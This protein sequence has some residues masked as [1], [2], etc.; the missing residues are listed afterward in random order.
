[1]QIMRKQFYSPEASLVKVLEQTD[2]FTKVG[3]L[4]TPFGSPHKKDLHGHY[5]DSDTYFG[6]DIVSTKFGLYEH[7]MND[8]ANPAMAKMGKQQQI[9]GPAKHVKT[10]DAGR[11]FEIEV[12]RSLEY[13]DVLIDLIQ[14]GLMGASTQAFMNSVE[15]ANDGHILSWIE[16][17]V[18]LTPTPANKE[19]I[20]KVYEVVKSYKGLPAKFAVV[21]NNELVVLDDNSVVELVKEDENQPEVDFVEEIEQILE[22]A[23]DPD[24]QED[25]DDAIVLPDDLN[26]NEDMK[27]FIEAT[28]QSTVKAQVSVMMDIWGS[29]FEE[30]REML[31]GMMSK[32]VETQSPV[33]TELKTLNTNMEAVQ[34]A[35][36]HFARWSKAAVV[37]RV[38]SEYEEFSK[39]EREV[40][41]E[42]ETSDAVP[43]PKKASIIPANA[44]G[45]R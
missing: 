37:S 44:P 12:A 45:M 36:K 5:F 19:T 21:K 29:D 11:W 27:A 26:I 28:I 16:N 10:D 15:I 20:G 8:L 40:L 25:A 1:M 6:D 30:I 38:G 42:L 35:F 23:V 43:T 7:F 14:K 13:H 9:L 41:L 3:V 32:S 24:I 2:E 18:S 22:G 4:P 31:A 17:E 34:K 33:L 39:A